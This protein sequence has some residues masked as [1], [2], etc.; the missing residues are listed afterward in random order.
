MTRIQAIIAVAVFAVVLGCNPTGHFVPGESPTVTPRY[1]AEGTPSAPIVITEDLPDGWRWQYSREFPVAG[2]DSWTLLGAESEVMGFII[3]DGGDCWVLVGQNVPDQSCRSRKEIGRHAVEVLVVNV[4]NAPEP[5]PTPKLT[6]IATTLEGRYKARGQELH[7]V[8]TADVR[9]ADGSHWADGVS[10]ELP[11]LPLAEG[12][13]IS[14]SMTC[15]Q[16]EAL[17][18]AAF[19]H[20]LANQNTWHLQ[21]NAASIASEWERRHA[22]VLWGSDPRAVTWLGREQFTDWCGNRMRAAP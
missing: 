22:K 7:E 6:L 15:I 17:E 5:T 14:H 13:L 16:A 2:K 12:V 20:D 8:R 9:W 3:H 4:Q 1:T 10:H 11:N 18:S 19:P 21:S